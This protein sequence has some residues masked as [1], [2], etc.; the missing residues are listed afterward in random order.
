MIYYY[1]G[2]SYNNENEWALL[3]TILKARSE[4]QN[5]LV[6]DLILSSLKKQAKP[7]SGVR[8]PASSYL[9]GVT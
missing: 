2:T 8:S 3:H 5:C 1:N 7:T 6:Y 9:G 4:T